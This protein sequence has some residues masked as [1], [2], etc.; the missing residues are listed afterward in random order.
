MT[1]LLTFAPDGDAP[2]ETVWVCGDRA[3]RALSVAGASFV[4]A[5]GPAAATGGSGSR[6]APAAAFWKAIAR[7]GSQAGL[8][9]LD[10]A[11]KEGQGR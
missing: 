8:Y 2:G 3:C 10:R 5:S 1:K 9:V 11:R 6:R 4:E 7:G